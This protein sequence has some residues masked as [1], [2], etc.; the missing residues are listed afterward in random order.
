[1]KTVLRLGVMIGA[2]ACAAEVPTQCTEMCA[3]ASALYGTCLSDQGLDW[4]AAG[5][6]D[7]AAFLD[8][9]ETWA[10]EQGL[11]LDDALAA[12]A[13]EDSDWLV[14]TCAQ[15]AVA[16][17]DADATCETYTSVDWSEVGWR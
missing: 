11:V 5:Y 6:D 7:E 10:W 9:C 8:S 17:E 2:T 14:D 13:T 12:G 15:R 4:S 1:M 3:A 16:F